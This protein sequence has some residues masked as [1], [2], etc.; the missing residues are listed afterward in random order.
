MSTHQSV[1]KEGKLVVFFFFLV[2]FGLW[3]P[4]NYLKIAYMSL[5]DLY[6][7]KSLKL[8]GENYVNWNFKLIIVFEALNLWSVVK[9][10]EQKPSDPLSILD[11]ET[12]EVEAKVLIHMSIKTILYFT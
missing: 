8:N 12:W 2:E 10:D 7:T 3:S 9:G 6:I 5:A 1:S 4:F 11:W